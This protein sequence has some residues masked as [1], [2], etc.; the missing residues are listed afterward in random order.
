MGLAFSLLLAA[1]SFVHEVLPPC[2]H[3]LH[4]VYDYNMKFADAWQHEADQV[5][6]FSPK[7]QYSAGSTTGNLPDI[8][9]DRTEQRRLPLPGSCRQNKFT[10]QGLQRSDECRSTKRRP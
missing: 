2:E 1:C 10:H 6:L 4:F 3:Y 9:M 5:S 7:K 8:G